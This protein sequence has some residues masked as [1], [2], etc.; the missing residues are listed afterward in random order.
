MPFVPSPT[1]TVHG[2]T[3]TLLLALLHFVL[4][5]YTG[6]KTEQSVCCV[7]RD[8]LDVTLDVTEIC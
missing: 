3:I 6:Q 5:D 1:G 7:A 8:V 4:G 2:F